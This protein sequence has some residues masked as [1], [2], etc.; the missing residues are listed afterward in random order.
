VTRGQTRRV[1][2]TTLVNCYLLS[3]S[4]RASRYL[5]MA[6]PQA[7]DGEEDFQICRVAANRDHTE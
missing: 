1:R 2:V 4:N 6:R 5:G 7:A 3:A